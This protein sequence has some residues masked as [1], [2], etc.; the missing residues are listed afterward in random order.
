MLRKTLR[1]LLVV[2]PLLVI[3]VAGGL[4]YAIRNVLP[5]SAIRPHRCTVE[6]RARSSPDLL[7]PAAFTDHWENFD[8]TV[9]DSIRLRGWFVFASGGEAQGTIILLHGIGSCKITMLSL[10]RLFVRNG[11]N[12]ILYDARANGESGGINSTF[13]YYEKKDVSAYI[14]SAIVRYPGSAPFGVLGDSFGAATAIQA[15]A[16]D[17]RL[18]CGIAESPFATL[19][20]VIHDYF[21]QMYYVPLD[22]IPDAALVYSERIAGFQVDSVS[23]EMDARRITQPAMIVHGSADRKISPKCGKLVFDNLSSQYKEWYLVQGAGHSDIGNVG[24][25]EYEA[26]IVK[27]FKTYLGTPGDR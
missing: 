8:I 26:R 5:Y 15:L 19:R 4:L 23:P 10:A 12:C 22:F 17:K 3:L 1:V 25:A 13:G 9:E 6:E 20:G 16:W 18:V 27:F 24:G 11:F 21:R 7:S 2:V 14:D